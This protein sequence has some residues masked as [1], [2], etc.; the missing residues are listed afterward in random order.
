MEMKILFN[1]HLLSPPLNPPLTGE[2]KPADTTFA[3]EPDRKTEPD[4]PRDR[5]EEFEDE[6]T[7][8]P[9]PLETSGIQK[10]LSP[11]Y[12]LILLIFL[13]MACVPLWILFS[14]V[15]FLASNS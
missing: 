4:D 13:V 9:G 6:D 3:M 11:L 7:E 14:F 1:L 5:D 2:G 12:L 8:A 15:L 10:F